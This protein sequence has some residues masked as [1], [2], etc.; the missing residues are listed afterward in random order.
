MN[1]AQ[2]GT[3]D[4]SEDPKGRNIEAVSCPEYSKARGT[5]LLHNEHYSTKDLQAVQLLF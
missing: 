2:R 4:L 5:K 3:K 1:W